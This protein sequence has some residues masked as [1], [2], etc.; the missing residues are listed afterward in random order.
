[1]MEGWCERSVQMIG[2][3]ERVRQTNDYQFAV[4]N[5]RQR[6]LNRAR[7]DSWM[8]EPVLVFLRERDW[9]MGVLGPGYVLP[10]FLSFSDADAI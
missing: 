3:R 9:W 8:R 1:M 5:N 6:S 7:I 4:N 2:K 10:F